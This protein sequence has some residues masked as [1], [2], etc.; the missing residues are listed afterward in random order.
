MQIKQLLT[1]YGDNK[2]LLTACVR[3]R[4]FMRVQA[5]RANIF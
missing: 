2:V 4:N 3:K 5:L 1:V